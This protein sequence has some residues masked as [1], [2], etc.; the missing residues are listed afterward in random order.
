MREPWT[1]QPAA[2]G[3]ST[4]RTLYRRPLA[5]I[6]V[7]VALVLAVACANIANLL[8]ARATARRHEL[9]VR[10]ALG[11]S[12]LRLAR[13][14]LV[15]SLLLSAVGAA[16]GLIF[17]R[18]SSGLL[19]N[20]LSSTAYLDLPLDWRV[21]GY[22]GAATVVTALLFGTAPAFRASRVQATE[23]L[24]EDGRS[25]LGRRHTRVADALV[26]AQVA[27]SLAL[28]VAAGLF[29]GTFSALATRNVGF[30]RGPLLV[31]D[32]DANDAGVQPA[33]S[34]EVV[35][36]M[37]QAAATVPGVARA[38]AS[39]VTPLGGDVSLRRIDVPGRSSIPESERWVYANFVSP[40]WFATYGTRLLAGREFTHRDG[41]DLPA[42]A[43]V[44]ETFARRFLG[45]GSPLGRL[46]RQ[47]IP[48]Y[49][50]P[51][52]VVGLVED[53]VYRSIRDSAAPIVYLPLTMTEAY[54][55]DPPLHVKISVRA[56][57][58][59]PA[60]LTKSVA[61]AISQ[62]DPD[63]ALTFHLLADQVD[64]GLAQ[65]RLL[66][67]LSSFFGTLALLL[68]AVGLYGVVAYTASRRRGEIGIRLT[69]GAAP[70]RVV[71]MVLRHVSVLVGA[72]V[73]IGCALS[74]WVTRFAESP[75]FGLEARDPVTF[76][77]A[78]VVLASVALLAAS[79][80]ARRAARID[81]MTVL[82]ES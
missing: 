59:S 15:E 68:A 7:V 25:L 77:T 57:S 73:V 26:V 36:R 71:G 6:A 40:D 4:L 54:R 72:G 55:H 50:A 39:T 29:V 20:Q 30:D 62:V 65:E 58:G 45:D 80:P 51:M 9:G 34:P 74:M 69:L 64:A 14:F 76:A 47:G 31:V 78:T 5:I 28:V 43:I 8:L 82:R 41:A 10:R 81:P 2:T 42:A 35:E 52:E 49:G 18:W 67:I 75:L 32:V 22:S 60:M 11:A 46:I 12:R 61:D 37:R 23:A 70:G 16:L 63:F 13:Q 17:A 79:L 27:L 19:V 53:V 44:N 24:K 21:L 3:R 48:S 33:E 56:A 66:A 1:L 38:A